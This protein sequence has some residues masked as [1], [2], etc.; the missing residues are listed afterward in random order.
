M[1]ASTSWICSP[2]C[3]CTQGALALF[4]PNCF[5]WLLE[6][7]GEY[8]GR[9]L[10]YKRCFGFFLYPLRK[11]PKKAFWR[12]LGEGVFERGENSGDVSSYCHGNG[13]F[14]VTMESSSLSCW[15]AGA[16][17]ARAHEGIQ[18]TKTIASGFPRKWGNNYKWLPEYMV[19]VTK[20][21]SGAIAANTH[22][23]LW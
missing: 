7:W 9:T 18:L 11:K 4:K 6:V 23:A 2:G 17:R 15:V 19:Y 1:R 21:L 12:W 13:T 14:L 20:T 8:W 5:I 16:S 10:T 22:Y 3:L